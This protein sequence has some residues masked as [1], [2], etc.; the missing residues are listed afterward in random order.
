MG[1]A[2]ATQVVSRGGR[3]QYPGLKPATVHHSTLALMI[4]LS[5]GCRIATDA[6]TSSPAT[7][8]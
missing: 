1:K 8:C 7:K 6:A 4:I 2:L 3:G 5:L